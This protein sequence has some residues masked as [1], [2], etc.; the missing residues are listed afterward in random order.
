M[1]ALTLRVELPDDRVDERVLRSGHVASFHRH[2]SMRVRIR[3]KN[4]VIILNA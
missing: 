4:A 3:Q 1:P 2:R